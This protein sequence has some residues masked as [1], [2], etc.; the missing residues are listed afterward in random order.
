MAEKAVVEKAEEMI[1]KTRM[2]ET[3]VSNNNMASANH[4]NFKLNERPELDY[5]DS[6][7]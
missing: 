7:E 3:R 2:K 4:Y 6:S 5:S 1:D